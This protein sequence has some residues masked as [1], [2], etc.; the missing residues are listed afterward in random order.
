MI[1]HSVVTV[2]TPPDRAGYEGRSHSLWF[3]DPTT[4]GA[5]GWHETAFMVSPLIVRRSRQDPF[6]RPPGEESAKALSNAMT[7][8]QAAWPFTPLVIGDLDEFVD[9]WTGWFA[10]AAQGALTRPSRMPEGQPE[11]TWR[12]Q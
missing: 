4:P 5:Y 9:R 1:A 12:R 10:A 8:Y 11:G 2:V 3:C 6:A 7:E